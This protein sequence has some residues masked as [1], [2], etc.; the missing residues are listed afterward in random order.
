MTG[1]NIW[2]TAI[3]YLKKV[4]PERAELLKQELGITTY[5]HLLEFFPRKYIDRSQ[6]HRVRDIRLDTQQVTLIGKITEIDT[7]KGKRG[8]RLTATF[9]DG[10]GTLELTWFKGVKYTLESLKLDEEI[11]VHGNPKFFGRNIQIAH[12]EIERG[13]TREELEQH[14]KI[15]PVYHSTEKLVKAGLDSKA[16]RRLVAQLMEL[17]GKDIVETLPPSIRR[18]YALPSRKEAFYQIHFPQNFTAL[19]A[20][21]RRLKFEEFFFFQLMMA[22]RK[23]VE[24]PKHISHPFPQVGEFFNQFFHHHIPFELTDAQKRVIKEIRRDLARP[25]QMNR[26][27]QGDVGSG[28][29]MVAFMSMLLALDNGFQAAMMAPTEILAE[30]HY[31]NI[32]KYSKE[33]KIGVAL[34]TGS[35]K[36]AARRQMLYELKEG[37]IQILIGTHALIE[38]PVVFKRLGLVVVDEQHKFGVMQRGKLWGKAEQ[39]F[40]P[41][42]M[43]MTATPI[44]RTLALTVYGDV[45]VSKID[46]LPVGRKPIITALRM[47]AQ[48]LQVFGFMRKEL[49]AGRQIYVVYP[50]V[51]ESEKLD[52]LAVTEGYEALTRVF[53]GYQVG[54]VHG[55]MKSEAKEW[56]MQRFKRGESH[57]LVATTVIEVGVDVP[58]ASVIVIENSDKFGLSQLHQLRGRVGRGDQQSYCILMAG[59]KA[60]EDAKKRLMAMVDTTDGFKIAEIDMAIRGPGDFLGTRQ[61]GLPEMQLASFSEDFDVFEEAREAAF[62]LIEQDPTLTNP[63]HTGTRLYFEYYKRKTGLI[64]DIA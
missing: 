14:L 47:E 4:G 44:P 46:G 9:S 61:S 25:I 59:S 19:E 35:T 41:H 31:K 5:S 30:Q 48:R 32:Q 63:D 18:R 21:Q 34:L 8:G 40:F 23:L 54:I 60:S 3:T 26:L 58:N 29:T 16:I 62:H 20:A 43:V 51:E 11:I 50:L 64:K 12:P 27:V 1:V 55:R 36:T 15:I 45:D 52:Y 49:E 10:S 38:D 24:H 39:G 13:K 53:Q 33:L 7:Q 57:I 28:K 6:I 37:H 17:A 2:K 56:E 42:N 22:Q